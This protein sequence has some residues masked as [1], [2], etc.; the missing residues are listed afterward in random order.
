MEQLNYKDLIRMAMRE[1]AN[2]AVRMFK[3]GQQGEAQHAAEAARNMNYALNSLPEQVDD[4]E[5][6]DTLGISDEF[7]NIF[8]W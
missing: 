4:Q 6:I 3:A 8:G 7:E 5:K 1:A 2:E